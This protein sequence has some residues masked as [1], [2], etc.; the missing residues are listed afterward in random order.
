[1][2]KTINIPHKKVQPSPQFKPLVAGEGVT[3]EELNQRITEISATG[4]GGGGQRIVVSPD[5]PTDLKENDF[6]Y[7]EKQM[8]AYIS[9]LG[10][11][12]PYFFIVSDHPIDDSSQENLLYLNDQ[13]YSIDSNSGIYLEN[14][15]ILTSELYN[16]ITEGYGF[17]LPS[18]VIG[19]YGC[20]VACEMFKPAMM[21]G[22]NSV[23]F[24]IGS[25][26][27]KTITYDEPGIIFFTNV[28]ASNSH[29][30]I[31]NGQY[32]LSQL[33]SGTFTIIKDG[34]EGDY[35]Q[36]FNFNSGT[37]LID[38]A[39]IEETGISADF[40]G[41]F[42]SKLQIS[43]NTPVGEYEISYEL[44]G[45][46]TMEAANIIV[47]FSLL[48]NTD[49][50][51]FMLIYTF[52]FDSDELQINLDGSTLQPS[53]YSISDWDELLSQSVY[54]YYLEEYPDLQTSHIGSNFGF[55]T[56]DNLI[57]GAHTI[58]AIH[59]Y[60]EATCELY[61]EIYLKKYD[62]PQDVEVIMP[63]SG[64]RQTLIVFGLI[65]FKSKSPTQEQMRS[66]ENLN[67]YNNDGTQYAGSATA[68]VATASVTLPFPISITEYATPSKIISP[69]D[70]LPEVYNG[71]EAYFFNK[72]GDVSGLKL[73]YI[74]YEGDISNIITL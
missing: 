11:F 29:I 22:T 63:T 68:K 60:Y 42:A 73:Q 56:I 61:P 39:Y 45:I 51:E 43:D 53:E 26:Y 64:T 72:N 10:G 59:G 25:I 71:K 46:S 32:S 28:T 57:A 67:L 3:L 36:Y 23:Y 48:P 19:Q 30:L 31:A 37:E 14:V 6:W 35:S 5:M 2:N 17:D 52:P 27:S 13:S 21:K 4:G 47:T 15:D 33:Q 50:T 7:E 18:D 1:M 44:D 38:D 20:L 62:V 41:L 12:F 8:Q 34:Q 9:L 65:A 69:S 66:K 55:F 49:G 70:G 16:I 40:K 24:K 54:D 58:T 74:D